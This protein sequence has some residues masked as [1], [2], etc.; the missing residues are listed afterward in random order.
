MRQSFQAGGCLL[1]LLGRKPIVD[2]RSLA[3]SSVRDR[4]TG[5]IQMA[6]RCTSVWDSSALTKWQSAARVGC[7]LVIMP[8]I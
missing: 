2:R 5:L 3:Q 8:D 6:H 1:N 4:I 7:D